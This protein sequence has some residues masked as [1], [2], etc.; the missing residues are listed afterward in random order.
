VKALLDKVMKLIQHYIEEHLWG[1]I[2]LKFQDG[3]LVLVEK[4]E[5]VKM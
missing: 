5:T 3:K 2:V 1:E 4:K